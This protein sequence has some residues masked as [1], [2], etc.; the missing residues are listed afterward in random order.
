MV[1]H[2]PDGTKRW[3]LTGTGAI[4][5]GAVITIQHPD[6]TG[7]DPQR[8]SYVTASLAQINQHSHRIRLEHDVTIHTS[9]GLWLASPQMYWLPD[10]DE[11]TTDRP[12][13]IETDHMLVRGRGAVGHSEL[14]RAKLLRDVE[15][16]LNPSADDPPGGNSHVHITCDGPLSFDYERHI[17]V[18]EDNVHVVDD[19]GD[20]YSDKLVTYLDQTT[21]T[22][23][24]AEAIGNVRIVQ[25]PNT[26]T[27]QRAIYEPTMGKVTLMGSPSLVVSPD[28]EEPAPATQVST[29]GVLNVL[30]SS[31]PPSP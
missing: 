4:A 10:R 20:L 18:F 22:I 27:G 8:T 9:D 3:E 26:A 29:T 24:Y 2:A 17:A 31:T 28:A 1:G 30:R 19:Q 14:K 16:V 6:G 12:V 15:M 25:G 7:Y 13:R 23:R 11:L 21:R 5:D